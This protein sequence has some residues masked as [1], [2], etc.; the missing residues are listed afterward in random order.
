MQQSEQDG[1]GAESGVASGNQICR[2]SSVWALTKLL[3]AILTSWRQ[4]DVL[5]ETGF[6]E[7]F[8]FWDGV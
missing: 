5:G 8:W 6:L 2:V 4:Q 7:G 3:A 1:G